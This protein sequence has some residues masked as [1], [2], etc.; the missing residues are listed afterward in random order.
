VGG[1]LVDTSYNLNVYQINNI[2][3]D[4]THYHPLEDYF[5]ADFPKNFLNQEL[6][7]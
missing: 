7:N 4:D 3:R 2:S 5:S 6:E 1:L